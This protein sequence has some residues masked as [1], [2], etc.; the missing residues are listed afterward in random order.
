MLNVLLYFAQFER[1]V[2]GLRI[3]DKIA[4]SKAK[5]MWMGGPLPLGYDVRDRLM[6]A[7]ETEATLVR[8]IFDDFVTVR[9][10][11]LMAKTY[12]AEGVLTKGGKPFSKQT[13][14]K[15]LH[16]RMYLGE[17]FHKGQSFPG[18]HH[19]GAVGRGARADCHR[20]H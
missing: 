6:M 13:I 15:M 5:G 20:W 8:R 12:G 9:S 19:P 17:I 18:H 11:T 7:N 16:N 4:A 3:R 10:A 14:Y 2:T 1:E